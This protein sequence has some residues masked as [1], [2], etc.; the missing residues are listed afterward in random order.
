MLKITL[1]DVLKVLSF[2]VYH[3]V[4]PPSY[5]IMTVFTGL[6]FWFL[7]QDVQGKHPYPQHFTVVYLAVL[8]CMSASNLLRKSRWFR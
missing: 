4:R 3:V 6:F 5:L 8:I 1:P 2:I 7:W